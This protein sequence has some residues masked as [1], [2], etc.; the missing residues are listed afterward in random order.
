[1]PDTATSKP[2]PRASYRLQLNKDFT[3]ADVEGI[4]GYL[5][6]LGISHAYL[7]P[8]LKARAGSAHGYDTVDHSQINPE[9]GTLDDFRRMA[10]RLR[11]EGIGIILDIVPNH[12]GVGGANNPYWLDLLEWGRDSRY[13][14]WFDI[15][16]SPSEPSL[17]NKVLVPFLGCSYGEALANGRLALRFDPDEGSFAAWAED[18]HKLP[19]DPR[20]YGDILERGGD[21]LQRLGRDFAALSGPEG[22]HE[23]KRALRDE[24]DDIEA[25]L[26]YLSEPDRRDVLAQLYDRQNWR[27]ARYSV[28][29]DDINYRRFFI[30]S[31][32]GAIRIEHEEVFDHV[33]RLVFQ[34]V[35]EGLVEGLR[36]DH[37]DGLYDPGQYAL[38]LR[39]KCPR[40]IYLVVEKILAPHEKLR[41]DWNVDGTTGYEFANAVAQLL[42]NPEAEAALTDFY[43]DFTGRTETLDAIERQA[44]LDIIDYEMAAELDALCARLRSIAERSRATADLTRNGIRNGLRHLVASMPVYRSYFDGTEPHADD[45]RNL[46]VAMAEARR[47]APALDPAIFDFLERVAMADHDQFDETSRDEIV[48]TAMR[49][50]QYTGPVMA[51][52]LE[53]TALYRFNRLIALSDVGEKPDRFSAGVDSFHDF[54]RWRSQ[55]APLGMLT[56]SS[57]DTKRGEDVRARVAALTLIPGEWMEAVQR[58]RELLVQAEAPEVDPNDLYYLFQ[59]V[60]GSWPVEFTGRDEIA[61]EALDT[62]RARSEAAMLK[63]LRE[64]RTHSTWTAPN[65]AYEAAVVRVLGTLLDPSGELFAELRRFADRL[66]PLG[67]RNSLVA[68]TLKL[69]VPGMPDIYQGAELYEQSLVDPDNRRPVDFALRQE[70]LDEVTA[71]P[72]VT[73]TDW[74]TGASK[75]GVI[76]RLLQLRREKP[77]L[78]AKGS[79]DPLRL[80]NDRAIAFLRRHGDEAVLVV[81]WLG[82]E[83]DVPDAGIDLPEGGGASWQPVFG[84]EEI[85]G[86]LTLRQLLGDLPVA[87][88]RRV[89]C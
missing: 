20:T 48:E 81:A 40:P 46:A 67:A 16:W 25:I 28:A 53:D 11:Q 85:T 18:T 17:A 10:G 19:I 45:R 59:Q 80:D 49:L 6:R 13:S 41:A 35:E 74:P 1:M 47:M 38:R 30:V 9:L 5:G 56:S 2:E 23:L 29:A 8:I 34:L 12:M 36:V 51:K 87:V 88:F 66:A 76:Q 3:F 21:A 14:N 37:V 75:L 42:V 84:G 64:A 58:W 83:E 4:A 31:D 55:H 69:T 43:R 39:E 78:F 24:A 57:H 62:F 7:S 52:G 79:Y 71:A 89:R 63:A 82:L 61:T 68:A 77:E 27:A 65:E 60:I 72:A 22:S 50:Q 26:R 33:H 54:N 73:S 32:L 15:N 44:K 86:T 70:V